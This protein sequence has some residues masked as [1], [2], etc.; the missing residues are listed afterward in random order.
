MSFGM[1][2]DEVVVT[3]PDA[4]LQ[5]SHEVVGSDFAA[6]FFKV[7]ENHYRITSGVCDHPKR[8]PIGLH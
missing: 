3:N 2:T 1:V 8:Q 7:D 6:L 5:Q 4:V